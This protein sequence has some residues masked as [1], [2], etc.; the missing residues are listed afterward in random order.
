M[1]FSK[2]V[3]LLTSAGGKQCFHL[4]PRILEMK[5]PPLLRLAINAQS[6]YDR[7]KKSFPATEPVIVDLADPHAVK[8]LVDG[9]SVIYHIGPPLHVHELNA[10]KKLSMPLCLK[11][12]NTGF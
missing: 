9:V 2:E 3:W 10:P 5:N 6:S 4:I 7:L 11:G 12:Y 8:K 1:D